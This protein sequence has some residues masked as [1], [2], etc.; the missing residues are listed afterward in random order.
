MNTPLVLIGP[1]CCGKHTV[2]KL[3]AARLDRPLVDVGTV[4]SKYW[5]E[6]GYEEQ[7]AR[8]AGMATIITFCPSTSTPWSAR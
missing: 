7:A 1:Q 6:I 4:A 8:A 5:A 2:G 3:V